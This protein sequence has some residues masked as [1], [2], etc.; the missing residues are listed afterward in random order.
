MRVRLAQAR[1]AA[2]LS[3]AEAAKLIGAGEPQYQKWELRSPPPAY[4]LPKICEIFRINCWWLLTGRMVQDHLEPSGN[5]SS[6]H[7]PFRAA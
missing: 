4:Y 1:A 7:R 2:N 6:E 5:P 3:Q